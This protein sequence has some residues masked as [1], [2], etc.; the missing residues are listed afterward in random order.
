MLYYIDVDLGLFDQYL[1]INV[2]IIV[3]APQARHRRPPLVPGVS[4][5]ALLWI[6]C[7][8][9]CRVLQVLDMR[10]LACVGVVLAV[11]CSCYFVAFERVC[12]R[13]PL[14]AHV[15]LNAFR[16]TC[17]SKGLSAGNVAEKKPQAQP[18]RHEKSMK[19]V[20]WRATVLARVVLNAFRTTCESKGH[21]APKTRREKHEHEGR[22]GAKWSQNGSN[23]VPWGP[24]GDPWARHLL[25]E[26]RRRGSGAARGRCA[27]ER[28]TAFGWAH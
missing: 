27:P 10:W 4:L 3:V 9:V 6:A 15:V 25:P 2:F 23:I 24:L 20:Y 16:T 22:E 19:R 14:L 26:P 12:W 13:A 18:R 28:V 11:A 5:A 7:L 17:E 1:L 21:A 8:G